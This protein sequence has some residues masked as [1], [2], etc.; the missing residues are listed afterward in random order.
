MNRLEKAVALVAGPIVG[1]GAAFYAWSAS[2]AAASY[3]ILKSPTMWKSF[4]GGDVLMP[5]N[6]AWYY[7]GN[8][9]VTK[10]ISAAT[11]S[12][13]ALSAVAGRWCMDRDLSG[14]GSAMGLSM[15]S[16]HCGGW[17]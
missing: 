17:I 16:V 10:L 1:A 4:A 11:M 6:Q 8:P 5:A 3:L 12:T 2:Y 7:L 14:S 9:I 15:W 13:L